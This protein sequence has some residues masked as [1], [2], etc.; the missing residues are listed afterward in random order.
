[1]T[2]GGK[3]E[4]NPL[5]EMAVCCCDE[6]LEFNGTGDEGAR[7]LGAGCLAESMSINNALDV[8]DGS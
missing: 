2:C 7:T 8:I 6:L 5:L 4:V 1:M 3:G